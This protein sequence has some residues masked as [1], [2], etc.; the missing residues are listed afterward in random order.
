MQSLKVGLDHQIAHFGEESAKAFRAARNNAA[1]ERAVRQAWADN[2]DAADYVLAHVNSLYFAKDETPRKGE[3]KGVDRFV[4]GVYLDDPMA[5]S[6]L[7]A[8]REVLMLHLLRQ[9][10]RFD[11]LRII[12]SIMGMRE[13]HLFPDP[14]ARVRRLFGGEG[15]VQDAPSWVAHEVSA[16]EIAEVSARVDDARL[17]AAVG[18]AM[19]AYAEP[20]GGAGPFGAAG[21]AGGISVASGEEAAVLRRAICLGMGSLDEAQ[22]LLAGVSRIS[23]ALCT[24]RGSVTPSRY[25]RYWCTLCGPNPQLLERMIAPHRDAVMARARELG[26]S[27]QS[28]SCRPE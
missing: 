20:A 27:V 21:G 1:F 25:R 10:L 15:A 28:I 18:K 8:R 22:A 24:N 5:R 3:A 2:P 19:R 7:N 14:L 13:R 16:A 23:L 17:A 12:P 4:L 11:E 6:E 26:L 9:G